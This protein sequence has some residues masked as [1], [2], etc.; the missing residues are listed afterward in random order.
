MMMMQ[1]RAS[2]QPPRRASLSGARLRCRVASD[3]TSSSS[4]SSSQLIATQLRADFPLLDQRI[5]G[6]KQL[7]YLDN[8][9]T[10]QKPVQ[11]LEA[12]DVYYGEYNSNVHRGVHALSARATEKYEEARTKVARFVNAE[13]ARE[14]VFTK[15]ASEGINLV[16]HAWGG[17]N[18]GAGDEIVLSV[19]EHH[20]NLVPWQLVAERTGATIRYA[21]LDAAGARVDL[22]H[23]AFLVGSRTKLVSMAHVSNVL[24]CE[25]PVQEVVSLVRDKTGG[26][27]RV[28]LD[29][30]QSVPH[31]PVDVQSLG[32]DF[33]VA[34]GHKMCAPTGIG[35]LWGRLDLLHTMPPFLGGGEM[36][37]DVSLDRGATTFAEP[38]GRFE[39]G[40]PA[41]C[42]AVGLGAACDYLSALGMDAVRTFEDD[43]GSYLYE[44]LAKVPGVTIYGPP[45]EAGPRAALAA[46]NVKG[47]H[48]TDLSMVLDQ[49]GIAI[50][51]GHHCTQPLHKELGINASARASL[52]VYNTKEEV[53]AF[54]ARLKETID[55]LT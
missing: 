2:P 51:S 24:G 25:N 11:V 6:D 42:E 28:L 33:L 41:I 22:D 32:A 17:A 36:I 1:Q 10:S 7:V 48:P 47:V 23:L 14:I 35:F 29:A 55:F 27:G 39:A 37:A 5:H 21:R 45:P 20:S 46:F 19:A 9:A 49:H 43:M 40:T 38:P 26:R 50:R 54:I 34:S 15:N 3:T 52:Y 44:E 12:M 4:S 8:A 31:M 53:Q 16:A 18:L 30:C 13:S